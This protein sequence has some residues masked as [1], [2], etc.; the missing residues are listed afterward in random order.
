MCS[1][2]HAYDAHCEMLLSLS[3][4]LL[5]LLLLLLLNAGERGSAQM[6]ST[7]N[8]AVYANAKACCHTHW[9]R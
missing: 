5:L 2:L 8:E 9:C 6:M 4:L 1:L 7:R 3:W